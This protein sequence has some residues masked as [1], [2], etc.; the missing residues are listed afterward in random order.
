MSIVD[1]MSSTAKGLKNSKKDGGFFYFI[2]DNRGTNAV[3]MAIEKKID[4]DGKKTARSGRA[5]LKAF[6]KAHGKAVYSQGKLLLTGSGLTFAITGGNAK[7]STMKVAFK[8]SALLHEGVGAAAVAILKGSK[9][10]VDSGQD[11]QDSDSP[12][13]SAVVEDGALDAWK[14]DP[15]VQALLEGLSGDEI[16]EIFEAEQAFNTRFPLLPDEEDEATAM[17]ERLAETEAALKALAKE[18]ETLKTLKTAN[19]AEA[20]KL[21]NAMQERRIAL[22]LENP[23]GSGTLDL[24]QL[25]GADLESF[26]AARRTGLELLRARVKVAQEQIQEEYKTISALSD[27]ERSGKELELSLRVAEL[28]LELES[29]SAQLKQA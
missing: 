28:R 26:R 12:T 16:A 2:S 23:I 29:I 25:E 1:S 27:T 7:P 17:Q 24:D 22:A 18:E 15:D 11:D 20:V 13:P 9:V 10:V 14:A 5:V 21:E 4:G 8:R 6:K 3:L 19:P